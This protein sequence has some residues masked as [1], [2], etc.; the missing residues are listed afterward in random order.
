MLFLKKNIKDER[1]KLS[2]SK[3]IHFYKNRNK[4][5]YQILFTDTI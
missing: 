1:D 4:I 3:Q 2:Y 5:F